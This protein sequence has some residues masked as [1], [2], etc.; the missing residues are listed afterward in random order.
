[1]YFRSSQTPRVSKQFIV[2]GMASVVISM[3]ASYVHAQPSVTIFVTESSVTPANAIANEMTSLDLA[4]GQTSTYL[5]WARFDSNP[6]GYGMGNF[7]V[8]MNVSDVTVV[9][10]PSG[11]NSI[12]QVWDP[13]FMTTGTPSSPVGSELATIS[14]INPFLDASVGLNEPAELFSFDLSVP[15]TASVGAMSSL[16]FSPGEFS[17]GGHAFSYTTNG[18]DYNAITPTYPNP[19]TITAIPEPATVSSLIIGGFFVLRR[20]R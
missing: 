3:C 2:I 5:V 4:I 7:N 9:K 12:G 13:F 20:R 17:I 16:T 18:T 15:S 6:Q 19:V 11:V 14:A 10:L 8:T 1:M